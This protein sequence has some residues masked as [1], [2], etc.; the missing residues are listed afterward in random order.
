MKCKFSAGNDLFNFALT[1]IFSSVFFFHLL[2]SHDLHEKMLPDLTD[3]SQPGLNYVRNNCLYIPALLG[4]LNRNLDRPGGR[5]RYME[6]LFG[7]VSIHTKDM[8]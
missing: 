2:D 6:P 1:T 8:Y 4:F 5:F 7:N 3:Q